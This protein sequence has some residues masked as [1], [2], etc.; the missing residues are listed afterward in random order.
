MSKNPSFLRQSKVLIA[1]Y[2][3][4]VI[5]DKQN[6]LL[7]LA[8]PLLTIFIVCYAVCPK[9]YSA[10]PKNDHSINEGYPVLVWQNVVQEKKDMNTDEIT[11]ISGTTS[12]VSEWSGDYT[13]TVSPTIPVKSN[14][15]HYFMINSADELAFLSAA[16]NN[17][18]S[19]DNNYLTYNYILQS[20]IDLSD[21]EFKPIGNDN[22]PFTGTFDGNGHT[23]SGL[24][25][26]Y[27]DKNAGLFGVV[28][29]GSDID[30]T[31]NLNNMELTFKQLGTVMNFMIN[32]SCVQSSAENA[33][34]V[35]GKAVG[36]ATVKNIVVKNT[37]IDCNSKNIGGLVGKAENDTTDIYFCY[38]ICDVE[39]K[40][41]NVGGLVGN[42]SS[43]RLSASYSLSEII[44]DKNTD[45]VNFG[46]IVG[47]ADD[48]EKQ[49][50]NCFYDNTDAPVYKAVGGE[51]YRNCAEGISQEE[52]FNFSSMMSPFEDVDEHEEDEELDTIY[53]FKKDG[54]LAVFSD[55]Q[56]GIF[57]LVCVA[58][59]IGI[60]NSIQ[61]VCKERNIL[62]REYMA[63]LRL[64]AY[65]TSKLVVQACVCLVQ[66]I[67]VMG[68]FYLFVCNKQLPE[69]GVIFPSVWIEYYISLFLLSFSSDVIALLISSIVKSSASANNFI[70]IILIVQI[71]FSGITFKMT[72]F[73]EKLSYLMISKY[74]MDALAISSRL[75]DA[76]QSFLI[77]NPDYQLQLGASMSAVKESYLS[78]S[79]NLLFA[80]CCLLM[81]VVICTAACI[82]LLRGV[83]KDRR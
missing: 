39:A 65:V 26:N 24:K 70:P 7:K 60:C 46:V 44:S 34:A 54:Q 49:V 63:N 21:Y 43:A 32:N 13:K 10:E 9:M 59:F 66:M 18:F 28:E 1:R 76:Q 80:W 42:L 53:G 79:S 6:L 36:G 30:E 52:M 75:N 15:E 41:E 74:G 61:E 12:S 56:T 31:V 25:V 20:D 17:E 11:E 73:M 51:D 55:T 62:K 83:K 67:L 19:E 40:G 3:N 64:G 8:I 69:S 81:F 22:V 68:I 82:L 57:Y 77:E 50:L 58:I 14:G 45:D 4:L 2:F 78:T 47:V 48:T 72:G 71:L 27:N 35:A 33:G 5:N 38:T 29:K 23:I 16:S 37:A